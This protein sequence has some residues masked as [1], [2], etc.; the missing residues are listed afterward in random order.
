MINLPIAVDD[1]SESRAG[2]FSSADRA[3]VI[4][5]SLPLLVGYFSDAPT[6]ALQNQAQLGSTAG[7][8]LDEL[9]NLVR[10]RVALAS[11]VRLTPAF[12]AVLAQPS[13][14]YDREI[15]ESVGHLSGPPDMTR[16]IRTRLRPES[17]RRYPVRVV[18]RRFTTPENTAVAYAALLI[19]RDLADAPL[20]VLPPQA[21]E[22][23]SVLAGLAQLRRWLGQPTLSQNRQ[24]AV[25]VRRHRA[26]KD[27]ILAARNRIDRA[28]VANHG[29]YLRV[30]E[31]LEAVSDRTPEAVAGQIE[32]SFYDER[33][34]TK[35]FEIWSLVQVIAACEKALGEPSFAVRSL[36]ERTRLPIREWTVET[37]SVRLYF[38]PGLERL[39]GERPRWCVTEPT[40][41]WLAGFPDIG[42]TVTPAG[43]APAVV[44]IDPKLRQR[45]A[46]PSGELYKLIGYFGN[47]ATKSA[48][49]AIIYN[50]PGKAALY[51]LQ[52][53]WHEELLAVGI[54]IADTTSTSAYFD[55]I[56]EMV[57]SAVLLSTR[58][59]LPIRAAP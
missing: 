34:D 5:Q 13:F 26:L 45:R 42:I 46:M 20:H 41:S 4:K 52:R 51:R 59:V 9:A 32:W 50:S 53:E 57:K 31:W 55:R 12:E 15:E 27:L 16:Y 29:R 8:D 40:P 23:R 2:Q 30:L 19:M 6:W 24:N 54:N 1:E 47:L 10:M 28:R 39:S 49:G 18:R 3:T 43:G 38:Q 36:L 35:L 37:T 7:D 33:F 21:P 11:L 44:L 14:F 17:P 56:A 48:R 25:D 58:R 22:Y